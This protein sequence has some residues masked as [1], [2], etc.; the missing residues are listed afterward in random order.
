MSPS[1]LHCF[2]RNH[3]GAKPTQPPT[4]NSLEVKQASVSQLDLLEEEERRKTWLFETPAEG[5]DFAS[6]DR[7]LPPQELVAPDASS[8]AV[9]RSAAAQRGCAARANPG[10]GSL[11]R[12]LHLCFHYPEGLMQSPIGL[13]HRLA[14]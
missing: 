12:T 14:K 4:R 3:A 7:G 13:Q 2:P 8:A 11:V 10:D 5:T 9:V 1:S 6:A